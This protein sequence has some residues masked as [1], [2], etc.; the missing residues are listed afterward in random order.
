MNSQFYLLNDAA[1]VGITSIAICNSN[2][3]VGGNFSTVQQPNEYRCIARYSTN[4]TCCTIDYLG[5]QYMDWVSPIVYGISVQNGA[6]YITGLFYTINGQSTINGTAFPGIIQWTKGNWN[7]LGD[8]G[9]YGGLLDNVNP[10]DYGFGTA[11]VADTNA[12]YVVG[13]YNDKETFISAGGLPLQNYAGV[14]CVR[15]VTGPD[16]PCGSAVLSPGPLIGNTF[17]FTITGTPASCWTIQ[18]YNYIKQCWDSLCVVELV[19]GAVTFTDTKAVDTSSGRVPRYRISNICYTSPPVGPLSDVA[20]GG[21]HDLTISNGIVWA[22]GLNVEGELGNGTIGGQTATPVK[23][24]GLSNIIEV[25]AGNYHSLALRSDG[26]IWA[27]GL[28]YSGQLGNGSSGTYSGG[29]PIL[30]P[31]PVQVGN[32]R[33]GYL[34]NVIAISAGFNSSYALKADGTVW[35]WGD[36]AYGELGDGTKTLRSFPVQV[37]NIISHV[38]FSD[39][40][41]VSGGN[42]HALALKSDGTV[43][44][45]GNNTSG[46]LGNG[47]QTQSSTPVQVPGLYDIIAISAGGTSSY[48]LDGGGNVWV[49]GDNSSGQLGLGQGAAYFSSPQQ[50]ANISFD[51]Y[52]IIGISAGQNYCLALSPGGP[53][54]A[55]GN[56]SCGQL[57][58]CPFTTSQDYVSFLDFSDNTV[59]L[60]LAQGSAALGNSLSLQSDS[61]LRSWGVNTCF[62]LGRYG[63][64]T[65]IPD[66]VTGF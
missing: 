46:Q 4:G 50:I 9:A 33:T 36:N 12:V 2:V 61:T 3:L 57:G 27:W 58:N 44:A 43:W 41:A 64:N 6:F 8:G 1:F 21:Y 59:A 63:N 39:V 66:H 62:Q 15:W 55:W 24:S 30:F 40:I 42:A 48:A 16:R 32:L 19:N 5:G 29:G 31:N 45:W 35:A 25:A 17:T 60:Q 11:V 23:T 34:T 28:D 47:T 65:C 54:W 14:S 18:K 56:N 10:T 38:V 52:S 53:I 13:G 7:C 51:N 20:A 22:W 49:W 26:K 37:T